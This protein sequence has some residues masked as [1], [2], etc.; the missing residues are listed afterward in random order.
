MKDVREATLKVIPW[1]LLGD[2]PGGN[3]GTKGVK[4]GIANKRKKKQ[5]EFIA[6]TTFGLTTRRSNPPRAGPIIP[7]I[8]NCNPPS[9][10]AE[11]SSS[12]VTISG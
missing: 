6:K 7:E 3:R 11:G 12:L 2:P 8:F 1:D 10:E 4:I 5:T 9:V